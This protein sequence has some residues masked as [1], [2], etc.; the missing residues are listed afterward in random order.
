MAP[1]MC[2]LAR[3]PQ[4]QKSFTSTPSCMSPRTISTTELLS[5]RLLRTRPPSGRS[6]T[7]WYQSLSKCIPRS[8]QHTRPESLRASRTSGL[9][10]KPDHFVRH[11]VSKG[12]SPTTSL[13]TK[14]QRG[15]RHKDTHDN[16]ASTANINLISFAFSIISRSDFLYVRCVA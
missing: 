9:R 8:P 15:E 3:K 14:C 7:S 13:D 2:L 16:L 10:A 1:S 12:R 4:C 11:Q 6:L 5:V